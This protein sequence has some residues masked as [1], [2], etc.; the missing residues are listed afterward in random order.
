MKAK[1][2]ILLT[3]EQH[4]FLVR[5]LGFKKVMCRCPVCYTED[6]I[7]RNLEDKSRKG[8]HTHVD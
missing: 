2:K 6:M 4:D 7:R 5:Q 8:G 3:Q 1:A